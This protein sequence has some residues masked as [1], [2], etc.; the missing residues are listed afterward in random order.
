L[1][2]RDKSHSKFVK[3][4]SIGL[5]IAKWQTSKSPLG[6]SLCPNWSL[7]HIDKS[8]LENP[9]TMPR[10]DE[11]TTLEALIVNQLTKYIKP[12]IRSPIPIVF[13]WNGF[14]FEF[15][16]KKNIWFLILIFKEKN[17]SKFNIYGP[18]VQNLQ[19]GKHT[20]HLVE[21]FSKSH[22]HLQ[23]RSKLPKSKCL[24]LERA[25]LVKHY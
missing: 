6:F 25:M 17:C 22:S 9:N 20:H 14:Y 1:I 7:T 16:F 12:F 15:F 8:S 4:W 21:G 18:L 2:F 3:F 5:R 11:G 10:F 24:D 13:G 19:N 23:I